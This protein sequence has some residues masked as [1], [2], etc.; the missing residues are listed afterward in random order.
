MSIQ[1]TK[2]QIEVINDCRDLTRA[3][4]L[5][6]IVLDLY[7]HEKLQIFDKKTKDYLLKA[8]TVGPWTI[9][10]DPQYKNIDIHHIDDI[11][12]TWIIQFDPINIDGVRVTYITPISKEY[13][14][15]SIE[16]LK[17]LIN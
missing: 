2:K 14:T 17:D 16:S 3:E 4:M 5:A 8:I 9:G 11:N 13:T 6:I 10:C 15:W 1:I 7:S 12:Q